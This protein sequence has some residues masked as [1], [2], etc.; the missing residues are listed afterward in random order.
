M[1]ETDVDSYFYI[2]VFDISQSH[3]RL[4][5]DSKGLSRKSFE[6]K[7]FHFCDLKTQQ[8]YILQGELNDCKSELGCL[9][10]S[11]RVF[12]N[13]FAKASKCLLILLPNPKIEIGS[14][15]SKGNL[16]THYYKDIIQLS[17]KQVLLIVPFWKQQFLRFL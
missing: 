9:I 8:R 7:L 17:Y 14:T 13:T 15:K 10:D 16:F 12:L 2:Y 5:C 1:D 3:P 11:L 4:A 6:V